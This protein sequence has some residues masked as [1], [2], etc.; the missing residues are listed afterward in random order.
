MNLDY[1]ALADH[2]MRR[3]D[4]VGLLAAVDEIAAPS[5]MVQSGMGAQDLADLRARFEEMAVAFPDA[6]VTLEEVMVDGPK[7]C[8]VL[9]WQGSHLGPIRGFPA[10]GRPVKFAIVMIMQMNGFLVD[11]VRIFSEPFTGPVQMGLIPAF[12]D[13]HQNEGPA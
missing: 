3:V 12:D 1:R 13:L 10:T 9:D 6:T 2:W 11:R 8:I 5:L 7:V 4:E